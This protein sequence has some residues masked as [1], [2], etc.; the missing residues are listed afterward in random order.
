MNIN[1]F[2]LASVCLAAAAS[3]SAL[4]ADAVRPP[5]AG[6]Q[7][8][9]RPPLRGAPAKRVGG[10]TR[11]MFEAKSPITVIAPNHVGL[12]LRDQPTVYWHSAQPSAGRMVFR[13]IA[14][15]TAT[16]VDERP[17]PESTCTGFYRASLAGSAVTLK[18]DV[19]YR[20]QVAVMAT[21]PQLSYSVASG[22]IR[23][24]TTDAPP[25]GLATQ[26]PAERRKLLAEAGIWYDT[27]DELMA[28]PNSPGAN[29]SLPATLGNLLGQVGISDQLA[30]SAICY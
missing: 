24:T 2:W 20:W 5:A 15:D 18:P 23:F 8:T 25:A 28:A 6:E 29:A 30:K 9:Y 12:T 7:L 22:A 19:N 4:A 27:V 10:A 13:L 1:K 3:S 16:T 21:D 14:L 26:S 11:A 17:L